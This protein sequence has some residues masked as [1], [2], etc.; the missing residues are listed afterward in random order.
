[1][2]HL[3][4]APWSIGSAIPMGVFTAVLSLGACSPSQPPPASPPASLAQAAPE[5]VGATMMQPS[6]EGA[7][8]A[9][10]VAEGAAVRVPVSDAQLASLDDAHLAGLVQAIN[11]GAIRIALV[12]ERRVTDREVKLFAHDVA[13]TRLDGANKLHARLS[14]LGIEPASGP[15]SEQVRTEVGGDL[16]TLPGARGQGF[17]RGYVEGQ[18]RELAQADELVGR[19]AG[20]VRSPELREALDGLRARLESNVRQARAIRE[21]VV[22]GKT[23][24]RPDAYDPDKVQ[25]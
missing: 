13:T 14:E 10:A 7:G 15:V 22:N 5:R 19:I 25:R 4:R 1:M 6:N 9:P 16:A 11:D 23:N 17:D 24:W 8:P 2:N 12:G 20:Y 3:M 21:A 18:L